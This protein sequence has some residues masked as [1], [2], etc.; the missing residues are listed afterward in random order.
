MTRLDIDIA[1]ADGLDKIKLDVLALPNCAK[2]CYESFCGGHIWEF[3]DNA[4]G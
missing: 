3:C 2:D 1:N 4:N